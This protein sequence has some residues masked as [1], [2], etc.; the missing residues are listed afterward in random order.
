MKQMG[1]CK[2]FSIVKREQLCD[3]Q[4]RDNNRWK[5]DVSQIGFELPMAIRRKMVRELPLV[6][7]PNGCIKGGITF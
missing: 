2:C 3:L 5:A 4:H 6:M 7:E 1:L